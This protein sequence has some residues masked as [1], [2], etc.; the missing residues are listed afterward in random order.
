MEKITMPPIKLV[1]SSPALIDDASRAVLDVALSE[2][3][4][5]AEQVSLAIEMPKTYL[6]TYLERGVPRTLPNRIRRRLAA[7]IGVPDHALA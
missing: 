2:L 1:S 7:Y 4:E 5:S 3:G 6:R